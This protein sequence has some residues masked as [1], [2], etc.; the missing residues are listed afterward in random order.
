MPSESAPVSPIVVEVRQETDIAQ[1][2]W[3]A[4]DLAA[5]NGFTKFDV[6]VIATSVSELASNLVLHTSAGGQITLTI[7]EHADSVGLEVICEDHGPGIPDVALALSDG[8]STTGTLGSGLPG[9]K[10]LMHEFDIV[11]HMGEG[12]RIMARKWRSCK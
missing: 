7:I 4:K 2:R 5:A 1:A 12:T 8:Y 3:L 11:S 6:Y 10:R 9:V